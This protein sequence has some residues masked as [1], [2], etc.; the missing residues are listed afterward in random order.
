MWNVNLIANITFTLFAFSDIYNIL[1]YG[2]VKTYINSNLPINSLYSTNL[3]QKSYLTIVSGDFISPTKYTNIDDGL[4]IMRAF[5]LVPVDVASFGNHE[6]DV[7]PRK[8]NS[9]LDLGIKTKFISTNIEYISNTVRYYIYNH[10]DKLNDINITFGFVGLC[11]DDFYHKYEIKFNTDNEINQTINFVH[12]NYNPDYIIGLTHATLEDDYIFIDKFPQIDI[13]LGG[14]VHT[15]DYSQYKGI[16][17][18][19]TGENADSLFRIDFY[20]TRSYEI[21]LIDITG[22]KIHPS[23]YNLYLEGEKSF[24]LFNKEQLFYF[25]STYSNINP[26]KTQET[27]PTLICELTTKYFGSNFTVLNSGMF[28]LKGKFKGIFSVGK[29]RELLPFNDLIIFIRMNKTD[30]INAIQYSN[31]NHYGR[32]GFLQSDINLKNIN[33]LDILD[34]FDDIIFVSISL[35]MIKGVDTNPYFNKYYY[36]NTNYIDNGM[37]IQN[38]LFSFKN[39][40]Y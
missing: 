25:N 27:L 28:K 19:R 6:F 23:I 20:S 2:R 26:R 36:P 30:L 22:E 38:I 39:N 24:E 11:G 29:S 40:T 15:F 35:L 3:Q 8:L 1:S 32:G 14:H 18:I 33:E 37:Y 9:S 7:N 10:I 34:K 5:N 17:I 31:K 16:P 13:I 21:N 4:S 12:D